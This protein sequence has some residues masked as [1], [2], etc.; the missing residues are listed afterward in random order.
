MYL[1][2]LYAQGAYD[3][4]PVYFKIFIINYDIKHLGLQYEGKLYK[5]IQT[6][7]TSNTPNKP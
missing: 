7:K 4:T 3:N 6:F 2:V 1:Q 5:Y